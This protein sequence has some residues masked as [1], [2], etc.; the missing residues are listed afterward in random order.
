MVSKRAYLDKLGLIDDLIDR[1]SAKT[2]ATTIIRAR[3][4]P[5]NFVLKTEEISV[6]DDGEYWAVDVPNETQFDVERFPLAI[7]KAQVK[8][9]KHDCTIT[10]LEFILRK[11]LSHAERE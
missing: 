11:P 10:D 5:R 3:T 7:A 2:I 6:K 4:D 8:I 1:E 9:R